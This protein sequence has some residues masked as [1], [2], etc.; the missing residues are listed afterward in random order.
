MTDSV[1]L[2]PHHELMAEA[3]REREVF[4][5]PESQALLDAVF[6]AVGAYS[7]FLERQDLIW[8]DAGWP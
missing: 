5:G 6:D 1:V 7:D 8:G 2:Y 3:E 4:D